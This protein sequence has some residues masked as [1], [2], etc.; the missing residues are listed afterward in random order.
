MLYKDSTVVNDKIFQTLFDVKYTIA[1][2]LF[3]ISLILDKKV[4]SL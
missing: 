2:N 4:I 1:F 3:P